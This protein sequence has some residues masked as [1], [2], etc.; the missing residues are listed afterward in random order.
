MT[1]VKQE[2]RQ[3]YDQVGWQL[4]N[5]DFYQNARYEDLRP[6]SREYIHR[7]HLRPTRFLNSSG[8]FLLDA[9][10]G[11]IQYPEYLQYSSGYQYRVCA[12]ISITALREARLRIGNHGLFVVADIS[13]LPFSDE[14]F[15]GI[16]CLHTIHHLPNEEHLSAYT[17]FHRV[18]IIERVGT[19]VNSWPGSRLMNLFDPLIR[20][21]N[22][23]RWRW[24]LLTGKPHRNSVIANKSADQ[25]ITKSKPSQDQMPKGT[26]TERHDLVWIKEVVG[27]KMPLEIYVW[28]SV[29][30]RFMRALIHPKLAG[31]LWLKGL[32]WFEEQFPHYF[33]KI[34]KY[35]LIVIRK[36][37]EV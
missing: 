2:V 31:R 15:D 34:G 6:V 17:E 33:G 9:G 19:I 23:L 29:S 20:F 36:R 25:S 16:V 21:A 14:V 18:L 30:V 24:D 4:V 22:R 12:D 26:F 11:P 28:R 5:E 32:Y 3:F 13:H 37:E 7:C 10:S 8:R 1:E 27:E 35:P